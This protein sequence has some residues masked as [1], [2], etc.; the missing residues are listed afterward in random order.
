[1]GAISSLAAKHGMSA[2]MFGLIN[3]YRALGASI[4]GSKKNWR[5]ILPILFVVFIVV[6][7]VLYV[8]VYLYRKAHMQIII[9]GLLC[10]FGWT[11]VFAGEVA[12]LQTNTVAQ[13]QFVLLSVP[14]EPVV[15]PKATACAVAVVVIV[16]GG[17]IYYKLYNLC[18]QKLGT[19]A[20][21]GG[22]GTN[23]TASIVS[24]FHYKPLNLTAANTNVYAAWFKA[25][26][27]FGLGGCGC[28]DSVSM[29]YTIGSGTGGATSKMS[30]VVKT[31]LEQTVNLSDFQAFMTNTYGL[32]TGQANNYTSNRVQVTSIP[33][34]GI[35]AGGELVLTNG[36]ATTYTVVVQR[37]TDFVTWS[38]VITTIVSP[39]LP[40][41]FMDDNAPDDQG[42]YRTVTISTNHP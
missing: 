1:M 18:K 10:A 5:V 11:S 34:V 13:G 33:Y 19:N 25:Q 2:P 29:S 17:Y 38:P 9:A 32:S 15:K 42:F 24:T 27:G 12:V 23:T 4:V 22:G 8:V 41:R 28:G 31:P 14:Q 16:V 6:P 30:D 21:S 39:D 7:T 3:I 26:G 20:P 37:T 36:S 40:I 35:G